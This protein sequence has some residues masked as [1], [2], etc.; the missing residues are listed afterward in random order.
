MQW[1]SPLKK[2][3]A[4]KEEEVIK[5]E[6]CKVSKGAAKSIVAAKSMDDGG[7]RWVE[8]WITQFV[9][10][11][12]YPPQLCS[13]DFVAL[14]GKWLDPAKGLEVLTRIRKEYEHAFSWAPVD[15]EFGYL[16]RAI[17]SDE[18]ARKFMENP[19][20]EKSHDIE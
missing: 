15:D 13:G 8:R 3:K 11:N 7:A 5:H 9:Q 19:D 6:R 16:L 14:L 4:K 1:T 20:V 2:P 17:A 18:V 10:E 12:S